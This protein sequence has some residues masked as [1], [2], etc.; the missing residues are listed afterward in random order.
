[1]NTYHAN[2]SVQH[3]PEF[4]QKKPMMERDIFVSIF[5]K[6]IFYQAEIF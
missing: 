5:P 6:N 3:I 2:L 4:S 1:M